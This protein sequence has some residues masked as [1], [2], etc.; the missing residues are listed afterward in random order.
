MW[1]INWRVSDVGVCPPQV[2][3]FY[4]VVCDYFANQDVWS[5]VWDCGSPAGHLA[6]LI[7]PPPPYNPIILIDCH[8]PIQIGVSNWGQIHKCLASLT[9]CVFSLRVSCCF[10]LLLCSDYSL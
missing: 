10:A 7:S 9:V 8:P 4:C 2:F 1:S 3:S 5:P 6:L